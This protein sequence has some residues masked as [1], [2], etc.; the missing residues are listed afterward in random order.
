MSTVAGAASLEARVVR[1]DERHILVT[2][3]FD[4]PAK[5]LQAALVS[6]ELGEADLK[7]FHSSTTDQLGN[8]WS[9]SARSATR[10]IAVL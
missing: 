2:Y 10:L 3:A 7:P 9:F 1:A 4:S 6:I 8:T 5:G